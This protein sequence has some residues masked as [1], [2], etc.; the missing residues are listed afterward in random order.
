[1]KINSKFFCAIITA[2]ALSLLFG[3]CAGHQQCLTPHE[4]ADLLV[5]IDGEDFV[6][7]EF[8]KVHNDTIFAH[9]S[10]L[11]NLAYAIADLDSVVTFNSQN[12]T[13]SFRAGLVM[14]GVGF[15]VSY[16][17]ATIIAGANDMGALLGR[18]I[19][20]RSS[21][22]FIIVPLASGLIFGLILHDGG[23]DEPVCCTIWRA[24]E[25]RDE[26]IRAKFL[27]ELNRTRFEKPPKVRKTVLPDGYGF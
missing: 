15:A 24:E 8:V 2:F 4:D 3:G 7:V 13:N 12:Y 1:M 6:Q 5:F 20:E 14:T 23:V 22:P 9:E 17:A 26:Q 19:P 25:L 11:G 10:T 21:A 27:I 18:D 16:L